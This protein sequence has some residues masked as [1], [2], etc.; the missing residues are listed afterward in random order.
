VGGRDKVTS[1]GMLTK[2][3]EKVI[4]DKVKGRGFIDDMQLI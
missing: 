3:L 2:V 1:T 4:V